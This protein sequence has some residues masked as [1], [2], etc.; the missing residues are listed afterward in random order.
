MKYD[1]V[2]VGG[3][4]AGLICSKIMAEN[5]CNVLLVEVRKKIAELHR[6]DGEMIHNDPGLRGDTV[7]LED[8][9]IKFTVHGFSV[10]YRGPRYELYHYIIESPSGY[11]VHLANFH[12]PIGVVISRERLLEGLEKE[13]LDAGVEILCE[14]FALNAENTSKG[15]C[16]NIR[17]KDGTTEKI[18]AKYVVAADGITSRIVRTSFPVVKGGIFGSEVAPLLGEEQAGAQI[19][20]VNSDW[21]YKN[22]FWKCVGK[23]FRSSVCY[24]WPTATRDIYVLTDTRESTNH[25]ISESK[26]AKYFKDASIVKALAWPKPVPIQPLW[27]PL[28]GNMLAIGDAALGSMESLYQGALLMGW[29]AGKVLARAI[30]NGVHVSHY[31]DDY[32]AVMRKHEVFKYPNPFDVYMEWG[33]LIASLTRF[34]E[35]D[36][37]DALFKVVDGEIIEG[38]LD[39]T[40]QNKY[41][42]IAIFERKDEIEKI[43]PGL[44][45]KLRTIQEK[46]NK[47]FG[48]T[49]KWNI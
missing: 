48:T 40:R 19:K 7:V 49:F 14:T 23:V 9:K 17:K 45:Q 35:D 25:F 31:L 44:L 12:P 28:Y 33:P 32:L 46:F 13:A 24:C 15:A 3:G 39:P 16:V 26:F 47:E 41:M 27:N 10:P 20:L 4:I 30:N 29:A 37:I 6:A 5:G 42:W 18:E 1:C 2:V 22:T 38:G 21:P 8:G 11:K 36:E 34:L 43:K